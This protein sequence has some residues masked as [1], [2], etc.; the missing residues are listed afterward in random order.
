LRLEK[1]IVIEY[2]VSTPL[3]HSQ[4]LFFLEK[5]REAINQNAPKGI[6]SLNA[7][8]GEDLR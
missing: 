3:S 5:L 2:S 6:V 1:Q 7:D 8:D 4:Q